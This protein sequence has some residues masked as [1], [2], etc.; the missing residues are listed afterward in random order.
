MYWQIS[1]RFLAFNV[2]EFQAYAA[3]GEEAIAIYGGAPW[4]KSELVSTTH[5]ARSFYTRRPILRRYEE[6]QGIPGFWIDSKLYGDALKGW[7]KWNSKFEED[8]FLQFH[9]KYRLVQ[10]DN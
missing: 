6:L 10:V 5:K 4:I 2:S 8:L 9:G 7:K 1:L 3:V